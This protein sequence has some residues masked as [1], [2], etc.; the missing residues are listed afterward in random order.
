MVY[1]SPAPVICENY[2]SG[3]SM[4]AGI[5]LMIAGGLAIIF[6]IVG[7]SLNEIMTAVGHGFWGGIM[8]SS[9]FM[10]LFATQ[11]LLFVLSNVKSFY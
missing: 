11:T 7:L 6:N 10:V 2:D 3:Q 5:I 4:V 1:V 9:A 8:V